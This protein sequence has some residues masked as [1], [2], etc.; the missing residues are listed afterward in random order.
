[1]GRKKGERETT[2]DLKH[3][4]F[5]VKTG[6]DHVMLCMAG[7][8]SWWLAFIDDMTEVAG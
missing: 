3:I 2:P 8:G 5:S 1:M 7:S 6:E 4:T